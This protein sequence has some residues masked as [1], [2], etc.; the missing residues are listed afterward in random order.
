[1]VFCQQLLKGGKVGAMKNQSPDLE[2][3][4]KI[5]WLENPGQFPYVREKTERFPYR[6]AFPLRR[7]Q[8]VAWMRLIGYSEINPSFNSKEGGFLR[9]IWFLKKSGEPWENNSPGEGVKPSTIK[10]GAVSKAGRE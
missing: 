6:S 1:M 2:H 9:R 5:T 8:K 10:P 7:Y 3:E 4:T